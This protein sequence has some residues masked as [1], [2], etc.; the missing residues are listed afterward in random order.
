MNINNLF[1]Y[2]LWVSTFSFIYID[3]MYIYIVQHYFS[4]HSVS[5]KK[6]KNK[7]KTIG[8][9]IGICQCGPN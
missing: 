6:K 4:F 9:L 2:K 8:W 1:I 7:I 5:I 3:K